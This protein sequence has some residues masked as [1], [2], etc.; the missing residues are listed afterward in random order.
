MVYLHDKN[1]LLSLGNVYKNLN[2]RGQKKTYT[3]Y[4][5]N[6]TDFWIKTYITDIYVWINF[7][8]QTSETY[9]RK[10]CEIDI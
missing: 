3:R 9:R 6:L 10:S 8:S 1:F 2:E 5:R 7:T 4:I